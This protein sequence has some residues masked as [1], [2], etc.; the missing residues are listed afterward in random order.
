MVQTQFNPTNAL[1]LLLVDRSPT[2]PIWWLLLGVA[3]LGIWTLV[4]VLVTRRILLRR[5]DETE[6]ALN[7]TR[8]SNR[9]KSEFLANMS[10]ELRTPMNG[11]MGMTE[12]AMQTELTESQRE[13]LTTIKKSSDT[14]L[15]IINDILD[16]ARA[17]ASKL[18]LDSVDFELRRT[19]TDTVK[20]M[21]LSAHEKG[22]ELLYHVD[23]E[24]PQNLHGDPV[25][26][27]QILVNL[28]GNAL[29]FT[30]QGEV[31]L[32]CS[33]EEWE[34]AKI[35]LHLSVR[36]TGI[37]IPKAK[38]SK[39]FEAF[40]QADGST[41]RK[42]GGTGLG[43]TITAQLVELMKGRI[44]VE[45][46]AGQGS[47]FHVVLCLGMARQAPES[48]VEQYAAVLKNRRVLLVDDNQTNLENLRTILSKSAVK[49]SAISEGRETVEELKRAQAEGEKYDL[50]IL[51]AEMPG[52]DGFLL[53]E[54]LRDQQGLIRPAIMMLTSINL[55]EHAARC[56][57]LGIAYILKPVSAADL[58]ETAARAIRDM[59]RP[60]ARRTTRAPARTVM[61]KPVVP[62]RILVAEDNVINQR[63]LALMLKRLNYEVHVADNGQAA[64]EAWKDRDFDLI[65]MDMQ[66]PHVDG[67]EATRTI[68]KAE[69]AGRKRVPI[70][71]VTANA[72]AEDRAACLAAGMDD[73]LAKPI[74]SDDLVE[75]VKSAIGASAPLARAN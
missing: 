18:K 62:I 59:E 32:R 70:V 61:P 41:T 10:H 65:L 28:L 66:M 74:R 47:T 48:D 68:R 60:V 63:L 20:A 72:R 36:D 55:S 42:F 7:E 13:F 16:F 4:C 35:Y 71:A 19:I 46:D 51:D 23:A 39:I 12:L 29:K 53:V 30:L 3:G 24:V 57:E 54:Q 52:Q 73:Y 1:T 43:L 9:L 33:V 22:L 15:R 5:V 50:L 49:V 21:A 64:I 38:Q 45:S 67:L 40:G 2:W 31:E 44:W 17:E 26:I 75:K 25:R 27:R 58:R 37:G 34:L 11:I 14:L 69:R 8:E 56:R 6:A